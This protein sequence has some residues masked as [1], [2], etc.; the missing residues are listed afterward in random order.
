MELPSAE[1]CQFLRAVEIIHVFPL[2]RDEDNVAEL[3]EHGEVGLRHGGKAD[4]GQLRLQRPEEVHERRGDILCQRQVIV[5][6][7]FR[8]MQPGV[9]DIVLDTVFHQEEIPPDKY[10]ADTVI[11]GTPVYERKKGFQAVD[12]A[13]RYFLE[14]HK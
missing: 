5:A 14:F 6:D 8:I 4:L 10:A 7:P 11:A 9:E 12:V 3:L 13:E 2:L 1:V